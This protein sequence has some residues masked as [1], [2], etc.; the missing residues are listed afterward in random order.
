M[1]GIGKKKEEPKPVEKP[2]VKEEVDEE[3]EEDVDGDDNS[4]SIDDIKDIKDIEE[5]TV[6][7]EPSTDDE[8]LDLDE[9]LKDL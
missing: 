6:L 5:D 8:E 4:V 1:L 2:V 9:L 3:V 7:D